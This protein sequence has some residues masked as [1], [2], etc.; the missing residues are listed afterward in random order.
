M[1]IK[2]RRTVQEALVRWV[3]DIQGALTVQVLLDYLLIWDK[4]ESISLTNTPDQIIWRWTRD[5]AF[6]TALAYWLFFVIN[7]G[8]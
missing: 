1:K 2:K 4:V 7:N 8:E 5:G 6:T 3:R